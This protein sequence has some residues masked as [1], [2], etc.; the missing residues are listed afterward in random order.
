MSEYSDFVRQYLTVAI[1]AG[2]GVG[3]AAGL[4]GLGRILRPTRP[5]EQKYLT[6]ESGVDAVGTAWSQSQIRYYV[7]ALM[8][9][10]FD[11]EAVFIFPWA[12]RLEVYGWFGLVAMGSVIVLLALG[13]L[14]AWRKGVIRWA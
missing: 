2:V 8:F 6:Y 7:F 13:L 9:V 12:T 14:H 10:I 5:Q 11:V 3:L 1:F 4:L